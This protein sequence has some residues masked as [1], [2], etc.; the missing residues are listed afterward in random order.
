MM[1]LFF[2][3]AGGPSW[4]NLLGRRDSTTANKT[5]VN[6]NIPSPFDTLGGLKSKF[7]NVGLN[8]NTDL[9]ALSGNP[10][11]FSFSSKKSFIKRKKK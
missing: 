3:Q 6:I 2:V 7:T 9:V 5:L 8:G 11:F 1:C 4:S 10:Y